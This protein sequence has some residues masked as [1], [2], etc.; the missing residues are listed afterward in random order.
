MSWDALGAAAEM[1]GAV[2]IIVSLIYLAIQIKQ[3]Q[4]FVK[5]DMLQRHME[6]S[7]Q[8]NRDMFLNPE[9]V[10]LVSRA[11]EGADDFSE[12]ERSRINRFLWSEVNRLQQSYHLYASGVIGEQQLKNGARVLCGLTPD[13]SLMR[14]MWEEQKGTRPGRLVRLV[15]EVRED[16]F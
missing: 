8:T 13:G 2:A 12:I 15:E 6:S 5:S 14:E 16:P 1:T 4:A 11:R 10:E 3:N 7:N 9:L